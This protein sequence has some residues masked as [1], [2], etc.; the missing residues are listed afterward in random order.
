MY[1]HATL[2]EVNLGTVLAEITTIM[3]EHHLL[4]P[5]DL[6]LLFKA[7]MTLEGLGTRLVPRF[8]LVEHVSPFVRRLLIE[9]W[10][11]ASAAARAGGV[12]REAGRALRSAPRLIESLARRFGED[13]M[14][15]RIEVREVSE[16]GRQ[17][18]KGV[19]R[20]A[21]GLVTAALVGSSI[22]VSAAAGHESLLLSFLGVAGIVVSF[23]AGVWVILSIRRSR[24]HD[25]H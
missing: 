12:A 13:G 11:P 1:E 7:L 6:A 22:L 14:A 3:R 17:L 21:I 15:M 5:A 9:R 16:F 2:R 24:R 20:L 18:E 8:K 10:S 4:L 19:D 25:W 23:A